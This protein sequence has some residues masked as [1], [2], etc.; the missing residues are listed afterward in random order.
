[1][2]L[3]KGV[4]FLHIPVEQLLA[5][6]KKNTTVDEGFESNFNKKLEFDSKPSSTVVFFLSLRS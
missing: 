1:M 5:T 2:E 6:D 4:N 3:I